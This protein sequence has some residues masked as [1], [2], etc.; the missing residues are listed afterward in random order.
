MQIIRW[1][2]T[3]FPYYIFS[4]G[5]LVGIVGCRTKPKFDTRYQPKSTKH[6]TPEQRIKSRS[7]L[8]FSE[9]FGAE[10]PKEF[11]TNDVSLSPI[12]HENISSEWDLFSGAPLE[13]GEPEIEEVKDRRWNPIFF[14]Y[15]RSFVGE[16]ER[17]KLEA[18]ADYLIRNAEY[19]V[20]I[21]GHCD[22]RGSEEFNR[23]LGERRAIVTKDYL[24]GLGIDSSRIRTISY[25]EDH[26]A[27]KEDTEDGHAQNRRAEFVIGVKKQEQ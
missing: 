14:A 13:A 5:L 11:Q 21:E 17:Q 18:L 25:G 4:L 19:I 22:N 24:T 6:K 9:S 3:K 12:G 8:G 1:L 2:A 27:N 16:S 20:I 10:K 23:G 26:L 7:T 15:S